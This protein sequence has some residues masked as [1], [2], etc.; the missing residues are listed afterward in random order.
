[1]SKG[2][3][4]ARRK[5]SSVAALVRQDK[6]LNAAQALF[7]GLQAMLRE[8]LLKSEKAEFA[9]FVENAVREINY[10]KQIQT[11]FSIQLSYAPGEESAL[12]DNVKLLLD[13]LEGLAVDEAD[14][15]FQEREASKKARFV[16]AMEL[17]AAGKAEEGQKILKNL[18]TEYYDDAGLMVEASEAL[19]K[20]DHLEEAVIYMEK[21]RFLVKDDVYILNKL[22]IFYRK[23]GR[24]E[25]SEK[26]F[27][28]A[29]ARTPDDP[30]L[31]FNK[32]RLYLDWQ[33]WSECLAAAKAALALQPDFEEARKMAGYAAKRV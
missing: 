27:L 13:T 31:L 9:R 33:R 10:N 24:R 8:P 14:K 15:A 16:E 22:G 2:L 21:A 6:P 11:Q 4:D 1:M 20:T 32:G 19:E 5:L 26:M 25:E 18:A 3:F 29:G 23:A 28:A 30:Y 12:L 7:D 17:L